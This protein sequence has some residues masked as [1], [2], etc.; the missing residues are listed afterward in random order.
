MKK[1]KILIAVLAVAGI[2]WFIYS[3]Y[4]KVPVP[5]PPSP[6]VNQFVR[7]I[8]REIDSIETN[9]N[10]GFCADDYK[11][12]RYHI[13]DYASQNRL[14]KDSTDTLGNIQNQEYL[15]KTLFSKYTEKFI[16]QAD[17]VFNNSVWASNDLKFIQA[18]SHRLRKEGVDRKALDVKGPIAKDLSRVVVTVDSYYSEVAFINKC[19]S[20]SYNNTD[21]DSRFP[22][23]QAQTII[24]DSKKHLSSLGVVRNSA[25]VKD[26]LKGIPEKVLS[27]HV[28]YLEKKIKDL[29]GYYIYVNSLYTYKSS[30]YDK[31]YAE[32]SEL[33]NPMYSGLNVSSQ[34]SRL[35]NAL[36]A[37]YN[38]AKNY[39]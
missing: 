17:N 4:I 38:A 29:S 1:I 33:S 27:A 30:L 39:F 31:L 7:E 10:N 6:P 14:G 21:L 18:E 22:I 24:N 32:I 11:R 16:A 19:R 34:R 2:V 25:F 3:N 9:P 36:Q 35:Q 20:F 26:G 12:V 37:D 23:E 15:F 13:D 8:N 28:S 5:P